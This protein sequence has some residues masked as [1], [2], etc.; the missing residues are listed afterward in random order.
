MIRSA[1]R[2]LRRSKLAIGVSS[3][4]FLMWGVWW[5]TPVL[6]RLTFGVWDTASRRA[7]TRRGIGLDCQAV[8]RRTGYEQYG[9]K[10]PEIKSVVDAN[11]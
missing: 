6:P 3:T 4:L 9:Y 11:E 10:R 7:A 1:V 5:L 2:W 8:S